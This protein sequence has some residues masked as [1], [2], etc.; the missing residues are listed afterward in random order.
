MQK[1]N[2][3]KVKACAT[4]PLAGSTI[5]PQSL[6][7]YTYGLNDPVNLTDPRDLFIVN[8]P[9]DPVGP[10]DGGPGFGGG[11]GGFGCEYDEEDFL[12]TTT[13][14]CLN[15]GPLGY[16]GGGGGNNLGKL[17]NAALDRLLGS[18]KCFSFI[19]NLINSLATAQMENNGPGSILN[20][21]QY[22]DFTFD[23][24]VNSLVGA[25]V[26]Q[27]SQPGPSSTEGTITATTSGNVILLYAGVT[28]P[29]ATVL[30]ETFH[31]ARFNGG[32]ELMD[33]QIADALGIPYQ[34]TGGV[35]LQ[36]LNDAA[37]AAWNAELEKNCG[38]P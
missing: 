11:G 25:A 32:I 5:S 10:W 21:P 8:A 33:T 6:N 37:S 29:A 13:V 17:K 16:G 35:G 23:N 14:N 22:Q 24:Y 7:R 27:S 26:M 3:L 18:E 20:E 1:K 9:P 19:N 4:R 38:N 34:A 36:A 2:N 12:N 28:D 15:T 30:H 31:L